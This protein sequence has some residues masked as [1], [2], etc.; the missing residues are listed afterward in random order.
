MPFL[1]GRGQVTRGRRGILMN[2][3]RAECGLLEYVKERGRG[4]GRGRERYRKSEGVRMSE[5]K[6]RE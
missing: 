1:K 3:R 5:K 2:R 6:K 4:R